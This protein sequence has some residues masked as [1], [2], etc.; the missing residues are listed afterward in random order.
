[1][2]T[3]LK[4]YELTIIPKMNRLEQE[5]K[6][7]QCYTLYRNGYQIFDRKYCFANLRNKNMKQL[8]RISEDM[9]FLMYYSSL[10]QKPGDGWLLVPQVKKY[11]DQW[12]DEALTEKCGKWTKEL[13]MTLEQLFEFKNY[14]YTTIATKH[15]TLPQ[16]PRIVA[17][18]LWLVKTDEWKSSEFVQHHLN[19]RL[20]TLAKKIYMWKKNTPSSILP[21]A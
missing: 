20:K 9:T 5:K 17:I 7:T 18:V 4:E 14:K 2:A 21:E 12:E 11:L 13:S 19:G 6:V 15:C 10:V 8:A 1:M 3:V 16:E